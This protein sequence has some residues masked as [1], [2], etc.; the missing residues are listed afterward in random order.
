[1]QEKYRE[2]AVTFLFKISTIQIIPTISPLDAVDIVKQIVKQ[3]KIVS[4]YREKP[5]RFKDK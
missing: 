2:L 4:L 3:V 5:F 1:M